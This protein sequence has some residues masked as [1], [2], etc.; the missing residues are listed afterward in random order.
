MVS[1]AREAEVWSRVMAASAQAP[2]SCNPKPRS[3]LTSAQVMELLEQELC[4][5]VTCEALACRTHGAARQKLMFLAR[6]EGEHYKKLEAI[7][8]LLTGEKPCPDRP[9]QPCIAC[10]SEELR[11]RWQQETKSAHTYHCLAEKTGDF[12]SEFHVLG[13]EEEKHA[14]LLVQILQTCL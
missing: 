1:K 12:A 10:L 14:Q 6:Q 3:T 11:R 4:D 9:K 5:K 7:Y 13:S 8:Y 2:E